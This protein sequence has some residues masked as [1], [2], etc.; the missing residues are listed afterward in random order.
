MFCAL[1][2][3]VTLL[4]RAVLLGLLATLYSA[5]VA[6]RPAPRAV[7]PAKVKEAKK[8]HLR[9]QNLRTLR[10]P[11]R[12]ARAIKNILGVTQRLVH[13][14]VK[15]NKKVSLNLE[16]SQE[17]TLLRQVGKLL[18]GAPRGSKAHT[19]R[20]EA[21][22]RAF[23][24][25]RSILKMPRGML[26]YTNGKQVSF[27]IDNAFFGKPKELL[28]IVAHEHQHV[29]DIHRANRLEAMLK[30]P[31]L[32]NAKPG[33]AQHKRALKLQEK[34][35][36]LWSTPNAETRAFK[37]QAKALA[38]AGEPLGVGWRALQGGAIDQAYP[39]KQL[40]KA[41]VE[42]YYKGL[43]M[44]LGKAMKEASPGRRR[45]AQGYLRG[46]KK[47]LQAQA[48]AYFH[49][50]RRDG[51]ADAGALASYNQSVQKILDS[52]AKQPKTPRNARAAA[53]QGMAH[54]AKGTAP[55]RIVRELL[56]SPKAATRAYRQE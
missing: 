12:R 45:L 7:A 14:G 48:S 50:A 13:A 26:A 56:T 6:A 51:H 47:G 42:G 40:N 49:G 27:N 16:T 20:K 37:A 33:S 8:L 43:N 44:K 41:L 17:Y 53:D 38:Q 5:P 29:F 15:I 36:R 39:P 22:T 54:A 52:V 32:A 46:Y 10:V 55:E 19:V 31:E 3:A 2:E 4:H 9:A 18:R 1:R 35:D 34:V 21:L 11:L 25:H 23:E 24:L 30:K 28:P